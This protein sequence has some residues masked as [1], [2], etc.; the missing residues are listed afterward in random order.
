[1]RNARK[2]QE[3]KLDSKGV[4]IQ[5]NNT[6]KLQSEFLLPDKVK[7]KVVGKREAAWKKKRKKK[8]I[9][10]SFY[11]T[12]FNMMAIPVGMFSE[13]AVKTHKLCGQT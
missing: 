3:K 9:F 8:S 13:T 12:T 7:T 5:V 1:M 11:N 4:N 6:I 2:R 10:D